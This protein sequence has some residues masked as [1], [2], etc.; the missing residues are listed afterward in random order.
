MRRTA[1]TGHIDEEDAKQVIRQPLILVEQLDVE[2]VAWMPAVER[3]DSLPPYRSSNATVR[4]SAKPNSSSTAVVTDRISGGRTVPRPLGEVSTLMRVL[5][6][7]TSSRVSLAPPPCIRDTRNA[8][9]VQRPPES[10]CSGRRREFGV[11]IGGRQLGWR[12]MEIA[13]MGRERP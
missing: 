2:Q 1:R 7:C 6:L 4:I 12:I 10:R 3:R 11:D 8:G 5:P 13:N 9:L